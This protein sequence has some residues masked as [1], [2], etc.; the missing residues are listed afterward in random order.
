MSTELSKIWNNSLELLKSELTELSFNTWI[1]TIEPV[2]KNK[3]TITLLAC[4]TGSK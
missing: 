1:K 2:S 4:L 3:N